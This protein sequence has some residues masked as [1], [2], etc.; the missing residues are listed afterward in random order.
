MFEKLKDCVVANKTVFL[1]ADMNVSFKNGKIID[2]TR[3][4]QVIPTVKYLVENGAKVVLSTHLGRPDG[5]R[6][7]EF[8]VKQLLP[9]IKELLSGVKVHFS[10]DCIGEQTEKDV[11]SAQY[12]EVILLEN[13]R[14]HKEE[15]KGDEKFAKQL[16]GLANLYVNEAFSCCHRSHASIT[17]IPHILKACPGFSIEDEIIN[18][19]KLLSNPQKPVMVVVG[20]SKVSTKLKLLEALVKRFKYVVV[21]GG[22]ANTFLCALG[23]NIGKSLAEPELKNEALSL[24]EKAKENNCNFILPKDVMTAKKIAEN[25]NVKN[26]GVDEL[27]DDDII[28]DVGKQTLNE[29]ATE[30]QNCKTIIWN[31]PIGIYEI[32]PFNDGTDYLAGVVSKMTKAGNLESIAG[33]GDILAALNQARI[34]QDFTYVST[35]GGAFL[36]WLEQGNLVGVEALKKENRK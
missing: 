14:F 34:A 18:L 7:P 29:I 22:M 2:D 25:E 1:R 31:G 13:L 23:K 16:A 6:K 33:G 17:G 32:K 36:E 9:T 12:G 21:G 26:M 4:R 30:L 20:G 19:E 8:S 15:E 28:V 5:E 24:L 27:S 3:I 11:N 10:D 35:A